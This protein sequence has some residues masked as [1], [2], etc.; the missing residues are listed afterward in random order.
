[1]PHCTEL[2]AKFLI[3][4]LKHI[5]SCLCIVLISQYLKTVTTIPFINWLLKHFFKIIIRSY[6]T[7]QPQL[8]LPPFLPVSPYLTSSPDTLHLSHGIHIAPASKI[9]DEEFHHGFSVKFDCGSLHP[10]A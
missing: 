9:S 10:F 6:N 5:S 7:S 2:K 3:F 4:L 8:L 1:M